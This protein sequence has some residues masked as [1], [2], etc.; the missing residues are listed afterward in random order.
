MQSSY[1]STSRSLNL[2]ELGELGSSACRALPGKRLSAPPQ[3]QSPLLARRNVWSGGS[4]V[5]PAG[6]VELCSW[7]R[8][9]LDDKQKGAIIVV[10]QRLHEDDLPGR[11]LREG[12]WHHLDLPAIAQEDQEIPIGPD[13]VH[14]RR[15]GEALHPE[16]EPLAL[17][18]GIKREMG[19]LTFSAQYLQRPVPS[20]AI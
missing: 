13:A 11:L 2:A 19:S 1:I 3:I 14:R 12:G 18:E 4:S 7:E 17:L 8:P 6:S 15:K 10:M 16:R 20:E 9:D 5:G